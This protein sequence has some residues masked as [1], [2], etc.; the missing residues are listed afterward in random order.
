MELIYQMFPNRY[1]RAAAQVPKKTRK[2][3]R[4]TVVNRGPWIHAMRNLMSI[5]KGFIEVFTSGSPSA[6]SPTPR[7]CH[8]RE[9]KTRR[10]ELGA[11][12]YVWVIESADFAQSGCFHGRPDPHSGTRGSQSLNRFLHNLLYVRLPSRHTKY[13]DSAVHCAKAPLPTDLPSPQARV[14]S[15]QFRSVRQQDL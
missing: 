9:S 5:S 8:V 7:H 14:C 6:I 2:P 4:V 11:I 13:N 15:V 3:V 1:I 12:F 10:K